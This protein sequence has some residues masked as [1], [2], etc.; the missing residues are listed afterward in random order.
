MHLGPG[1]QINYVDEILNKYRE[2]PGYI[3]YNLSEESLFSK[4]YNT[5]ANSLKSIAPFATLIGSTAIA[6]SITKTAADACL[7]TVLDRDIHS[8]ANEFTKNTFIANAK[9]GIWGLSFALI[10]FYIKSYLNN[11]EL[12]RI[13]IP[14]DHATAI[15]LGYDTGKSIGISSS[16][17][18]TRNK[19]I[20]NIF[21]RNIAS[22]IFTVIGLYSYYKLFKYLIYN[23]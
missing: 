17:F 11:N 12:P 19:I 1:H 15:K 20:A 16:I 9:F 21:D 5:A 4:V 8:F 14:K 2:Q 22:K 3:R 13:S 7:N 23:E 18:G 10:L 6:T